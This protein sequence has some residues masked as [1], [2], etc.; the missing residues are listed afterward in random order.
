MFGSGNLLFS[1]RSFRLFR[2]DRSV[3]AE[4]FGPPQVRAQ[5]RVSVIIPTLN[6]ARNL[7]IVLPHIPRD[8]HEVILVDG[9]SVDD[10]IEVARS[11]LPS[12]R[13]VIEPQR[14]KGAALCAGFRAAEGEIIVMLDADGSTDP[15]EIPRFVDALLG[16]ADFAKGSRFLADGGST[17]ISR[18]RAIGNWGFLSLVR[19]LFGGQYTDLCYG[20]NAFWASVLPVLALDGTGFE[21]ETMM[22]VRALREGLRVA[23]V[24]SFERSRVFGASNL[25]TFRDGWRVLRTI[26]RERP[27]R[28]QSPAISDRPLTIPEPP[29]P[30]LRDANLPHLVP[31][32]GL[33]GTD[34]LQLALDGPTVVEAGRETSLAAIG[35]EPGRHLVPV[36]DSSAASNVELDSGHPA[37]I[38]AEGNASHESVGD[39]VMAHL[40]PVIDMLRAGL[41]VALDGPASNASEGEPSLAF[42]VGGED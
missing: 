11:L 40:A 36:M 35:D 24:P 25:R 21:I 17:D 42:A 30:V 16:G 3:A 12:I 23:E 37:L 31:V 7:P 26:V 34:Q 19:I 22:N 15:T 33:L 28:R 9:L 14:G 10:T 6:E 18:L 27:Q 32:M 41:E 38:T 4:P 2:N 8:V 29:F 5:A 1:L 13:V 20:Y 39:E